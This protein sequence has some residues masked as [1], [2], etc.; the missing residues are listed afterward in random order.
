MTRRALDLH[1][2]FLIYYVYDAGCPN[3][4]AQFK[5]EITQARIRVFQCGLLE[6]QDNTLGFH[7]GTEQQNRLN[8]Q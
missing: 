2:A 5:I 6:I 1:I 7:L 3:K 4:D 8:V